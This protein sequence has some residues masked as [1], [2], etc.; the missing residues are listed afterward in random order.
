MKYFTFS[1]L[2]HTVES[3]FAIA[4]SELIDGAVVSIQ[5]GRYPVSVYPMNPGSGPPR[6][7][8]GTYLVRVEPD[9]TLRVVDKNMDVEE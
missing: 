4:L 3:A 5:A 7:F 9:L 1:P 2:E 8:P 6:A